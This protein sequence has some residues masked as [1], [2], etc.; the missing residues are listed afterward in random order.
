MQ[1]FL[2]AGALSLATKKV[3]K[4]R[5]FRLSTQIQSVTISRENKRS[6]KTQGHST[7]NVFL[8]VQRYLLPWKSTPVSLRHCWAGRGSPTVSR[9]T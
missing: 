7:R 8:Q 2:K 9:D 1:T 3:T 6:L 5:M 4:M